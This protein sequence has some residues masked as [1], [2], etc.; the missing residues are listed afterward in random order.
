MNTSKI[1]NH[2]N[3]SKTTNGIEGRGGVSGGNLEK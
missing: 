2:N 1:Q 3:F